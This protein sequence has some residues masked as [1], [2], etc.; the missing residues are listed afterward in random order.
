MSPIKVVALDKQ[1]IRIKIL[2]IITNEY[3]CKQNLPNILRGTIKIND[4]GILILII[5]CNAISKL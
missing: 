2:T 1:D 4:S 3:L 5:R